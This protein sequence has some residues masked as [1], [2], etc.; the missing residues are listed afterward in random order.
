MRK[1]YDAPQTPC[2]RLLASANV[3]EESKEKMRAVLA[4]LDPLRLLDEI[5]TMQGHISGLARGEPAHTAPQ[6]DGDLDRF[7]ASLSCLWKDGEVRPTH[8]SKP[9]V[10]RYWRTRVDPFAD[11]WPKV[12]VWL[13]SEP[14]QTAKELFARLRMQHP[15][16]FQAGQLRT[17]QRRVKEWRM[18]AARRLVFSGA[19]HRE[20][21]QLAGSDG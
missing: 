9:K 14:D 11:V 10:A 6:R 15:D 8:R 5:R 19:T 3:T 2:A 7:L 1:Q 18:A 17:L 20:H 4:S 13:E 21:K 16:T 12:L